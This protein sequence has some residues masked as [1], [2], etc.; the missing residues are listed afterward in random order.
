MTTMS[1]MQSRNK[2]ARISTLRQHGLS[3]VELMV[4][5]AIG[6]LLTVGLMTM[7][8]GT[9]RSF[10]IQDD[11][12]RMQEN[13][14]LALNYL[15]ADIRMAG[16]YGMARAA[17]NITDPTGLIT[18]VNDC[19]SAANPPAANWAID[20]TRPVFGFSG[21]TAATVNG[22]FPCIAS[23]NFQDGPILVIR[24]A[25]GQLL[26]DPNNDGNLTDGTNIANPDFNPNALYIQT[27]PALG[28]VFVGSTFPTLR[29]DGLTAK[30]DGAVP[31]VPNDA[32]I[33]EYLARVYYIRPCSRPNGGGAN[34]TGAAD[35]AGRPIPTLVRQE[36]NALTM[37]ESLVAEGIERSSFLYGIDADLDGIPERF[38]ADPT[39]A[40]WAD[41][42]AVRV[43]V[44]ARS[45]SA[46]S[47]HDDSGKTYDLDGTGAA[48]PFTCTVG[49]NC[50]YKRKVFTQ[51]FQTRNLAMRRGA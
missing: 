46:I 38:V 47:G 9:S 20:T 28:V 21:L 39:L 29:A 41:V 45:P 7:V 2:S 44:L 23:S 5:L 48:V 34:C 32:P 15:G 24:R 30:I 33:F 42:V 40:Q 1:T 18:T 10:Q 36:L 3:L 22:T 31:G 14:A 49:V 13:S 8:A 51:T 27:E 43:A 6:M 35:D 12:A 16:F 26:R 50:N 4:G 11:F 17:T 25:N 19:G 37:V